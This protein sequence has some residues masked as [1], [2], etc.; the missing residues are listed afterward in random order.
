MKKVMI[1]EEGPDSSTSLARVVHP[2]NPVATVDELVKSLIA[3]GSITHVKKK[4]AVYAEGKAAT[5]VFYILKGKVKTCKWNE[6]G[7]ELITGL[8]QVGDFIGFDALM[9]GAR[10]RD[11]AVVIEEAAFI[12]IARA[13]FDFLFRYNN[14]FLRKFVDILTGN[15]AEKQE[16]MLRMAY[17]PLRKKV[18]EALLHTYRKYN[19]NNL[20][21]FSID[22]SRYNLAALA[23]VARESLIRTLSDLRDE[24]FIDIR[25][26][27]IVIPDTRKLEQLIYSNKKPAA[28]ANE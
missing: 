18:A 16:Q 10:Y 7:K 2:L 12:E 23:G 24:N 1:P 19:P 27:K 25:N 26:G 15:I 4:R 3:A 28:Q 5:A 20:Q 6:E 21:E 14:S 11:T 22:I 9:D 17:S 8:Y 13:D